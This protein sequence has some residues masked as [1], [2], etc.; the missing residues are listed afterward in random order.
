MSILVAEKISK[1]YSEKILFDEISIG[2]NEGEKIGLIGI[3]GTGKSTFLKVIA[4]LEPLDAGKIICGNDMKIG[5]LAQIPNF[6]PGITVLE[7][8]FKGDTPEMQL[9]RRYEEVLQMIA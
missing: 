7:Q 9:I 2:I 4:G 6:E 3:N 8:V 1:K 5:Y